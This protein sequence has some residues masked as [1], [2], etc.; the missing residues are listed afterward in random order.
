MSA[1]HDFD[2]FT[3]HRPSGDAKRLPL[4]TVY[5]DNRRTWLVTSD[6]EMPQPAELRE[7]AEHLTRC[8]DE[9]EPQ[10]YLFTHQDA[11]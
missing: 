4:L 10:P 3:L 9:R 1:R 5:G 8:A 2:W 7:I 11:P 6:G